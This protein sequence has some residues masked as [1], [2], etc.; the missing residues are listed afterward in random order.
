[1]VY[2]TDVASLVTDEELQN[3]I[4]IA[5][6][7]ILNQSGLYALE[8]N[9]EANEIQ[10]INQNTG[11]T[12]KISTLDFI[13]DG[14]ID[15][16]ELSTDKKFL[17]IIWNTDAGKQTTSVPM[18][19]FIDKYIGQ[20]TDTI[21]LTINNNTVSAE[22]KTGALTDA[23]LAANANIEASKLSPEIRTKLEKA[24]TAV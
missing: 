23:H 7:E 17:N 20:N 16:V 24:H 21:N 4:D 19:S 11:E 22:V 1:L 12:S 8:Y 18:E 14:M 10:L 5:K 9:K 3:A 2:I 15:K 6:E 13:K